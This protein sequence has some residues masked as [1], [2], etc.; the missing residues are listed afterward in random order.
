MGTKDQSGGYPVPRI[1]IDWEDMHAILVIR[2]E[3]DPLKVTY[4]DILGP[5]AAQTIAKGLGIPCYRQEQ[6][7][8]LK[9]V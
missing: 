4:I 7:L 8:E 6:V 3:E 2:S 5:V 1:E 9:E